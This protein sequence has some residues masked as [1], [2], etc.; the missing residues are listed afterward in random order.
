LESSEILLWMTVI[1]I[2]AGIVSQIGAAFL[3]IPSIVPLL[4]I[5]IIIGPEI[6]GLLDPQLFG[7]GFEAIIKLCVAIILFEAGL[8]LDKD[9]IKK[10]QSVIL[11][12]ISIGSLITLFCTAVFTNLILSISW[13]LSFLFG[14]LV[15]VTGPTVIKPLLKRTNIGSRLRNIL[16]SEGTFID[17][18]GAIIAL[19]VLEIVLQESSSFIYSFVL[20]FVRLGIG[21]LIGVIGGYIIGKLILKWS[22]V[23]E[24]I[25]ELMV[26]AAALSVYALSESVLQE[27]GLMAAVACG[28]VLG[29]MEIPEEEPL[30]KFKGKLS[31][32]VISFLFILLAASLK[33][34]FITS[35]GIGGILVV[36]SIIFLVRP[37]QIFFTT[38]G[39][40]IPIVRNTKP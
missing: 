30:K 10:D 20:V 37:I 26:L 40:D 8:N 14:S 34:E 9:E 5:G 2:A 31:I 38:L 17:P 1:T 23:L 6:L 4:I 21:A 19:F 13:S 36:F 12:L 33:I 22:I 29:H 39:T 28:A 24:E 27:S 16:E 32:F 35:L 7:D 15:I 25:I 3:G 11:R 18:I